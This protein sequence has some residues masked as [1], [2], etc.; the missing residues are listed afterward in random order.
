MLE[1]IE[2]GAGLATLG[3]FGVLSWGGTVRRL[4]RSRHRRASI[5]KTRPT[6]PNL[7]ALPRPGAKPRTMAATG[8]AHSGGRM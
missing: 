6:F 7:V 8:T 5:S 3:V 4:Y 2:V 1:L